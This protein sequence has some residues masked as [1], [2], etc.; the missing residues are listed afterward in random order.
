MIRKLALVCLSAASLSACAYP[1]TEEFQG[2][3]EG[4][5]IVRSGPSLASV[6]VD[7]KLVGSVA[8]TQTVKGAV[9]LPSGAHKIRVV[10]GGETLLDRTVYVD[11]GAKVILDVGS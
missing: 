7:G 5:L 6:F 8:E 9:K 11:N 1:S 4:R 2:G 10:L 3:P